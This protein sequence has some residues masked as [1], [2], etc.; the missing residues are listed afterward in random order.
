[1]RCVS[2]SGCDATLS[3]TQTKS[4]EQSVTALHCV[5]IT[6]RDSAPTALLYDDDLASVPDA[7]RMPLDAIDSEVRS[8]E[9][10]AAACAALLPV[11]RTGG[12][13]SAP[14]HAEHRGPTEAA[15]S[16][17]CASST[18]PA[19]ASGA[20]G[21]ESSGARDLPPPSPTQAA[22]GDCSTAGAICYR[23][24]RSAQAVIGVAVC[25]RP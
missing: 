3:T 25:C 23:C 1:V 5:I 12:A 10:K 9:A 15:S 8:L 11:A 18:A 17:H 24:W 20:E 16:C 19:T 14:P 13:H 7:A 2:H 22:A 21:T 6:L 4:F